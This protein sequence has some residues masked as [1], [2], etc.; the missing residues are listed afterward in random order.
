MIDPLCRRVG[1]KLVWAIS[2]F[3]ICVCMASTAVI[4]AL[5]I[6]K[7]AHQKYSKASWAK[8]AAVSVFAVLGLPLAVSVSQI[9]C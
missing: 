8:N 2:N 6:H 4:S 3:V 1:T 7:D 5:A 9:M